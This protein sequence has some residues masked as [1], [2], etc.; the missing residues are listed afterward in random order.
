MDATSTI[1][2]HPRARILPEFHR[3]IAFEHVS[4][5]YDNEPVLRGVSLTIAAGER[6]ALVGPSGG[7]KTTLVNLL[8]RFYDP[9][10]GRVKIDG[11]DLKHVTLKSLRS[12]VAVVAQETMLFQ[13]TVRANL[14]LGQPDASLEEIVEA[15][16]AA[17]AH[18][19]ISRLPKGYDTVIGERGAS[20]SGGERQRLAIARAFLKNPP[21]LILD[22]ATSQLDA[23]SE[24]A[25]TQALE[26]VMKD[27]T[28]L[29]IA[30]RLSTVH[31]ADRILLIQE[32][33]IV[34]SG[35]HSDL[36]HKSAL[37]RRFCELQ[38]ITGPLRTVSAKSSTT[39][40]TKKR[41]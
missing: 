22:E 36:M 14:S 11:I 3:E 35:R 41:S 38:L 37:Y 31:M 17:N 18:G 40:E 33:R 13:D 4:F 6:I 7:G 1:I 8:P 28:V 16:K 19:F 15:A 25:I 12:Q 23:E 5:A 21:V 9:Q 32:G 2:E 10:A 24:H 20:L 26:R 27:R 29:L 30:H 34:E 39:G